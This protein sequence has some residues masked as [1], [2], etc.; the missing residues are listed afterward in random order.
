MVILGHIATW[1]DDSINDFVKNA[2]LIKQE[3]RFTLTTSQH[4]EKAGK[5]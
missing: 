5:K 1:N 4:V 2:A 3:A